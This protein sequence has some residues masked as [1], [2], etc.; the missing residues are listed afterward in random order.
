MERARQIAAEQRAAEEERR[1]REG[2]KGK[3]KP[4]DDGIGSNPDTSMKRRPIGVRTKGEL[5]VAY[6]YLES[7]PGAQSIY[8]YSGNG[9]AY[10]STDIT[11]PDDPSESNYTEP[12]SNPFYNSYV[13]ASV[14]YKAVTSGGV[15]LPAGGTNLIAAVQHNFYVQSITQ[16]FWYAAAASPP[17]AQT[18]DNGSVVSTQVELCFVIGRDSLRQIRCPAAVSGIMQRLQPGPPEW[19][20]ADFR[21][22]LLPDGSISPDWFQGKVILDQPSPQSY[23]AS[24]SA[25][26]SYGMQFDAADISVTAGI[27]TSFTDGRNRLEDASSYT[28]A[29]SILLAAAAPIPNVYLESCR[30]AN[31]CSGD[32]GILNADVSRTIPVSTLGTD[33]LTFEENRAPALTTTRPESHDP[34]SYVNSFAAWDWGNPAYCQQKLISL[35][36]SQEDFQ[37]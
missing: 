30:L 34:F 29:A 8:A 28:E 24:G 18:I 15:I 33:G 13:R 5:P 26:D 22:Y 11:L 25:L 12:G 21:D 3:S 10:L 32:G 14:N 2:L 6:G 27:F 35:G 17:Y 20:G 1:R 9:L 23:P 36:F 7:G 19:S 16:A 4:G 37:P 31:T